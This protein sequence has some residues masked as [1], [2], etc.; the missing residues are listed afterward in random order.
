MRGRGYGSSAAAAASRRA[1]AAG[2][3]TCMLLTDL[4]NPTS[5]KI[6]AHIGYRR[7]ADFAMFEFEATLR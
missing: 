2:A 1:L 7:F 6:Y 5:N 4:G 3:H